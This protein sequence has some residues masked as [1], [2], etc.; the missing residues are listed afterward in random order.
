LAQT[1]GSILL[2]GGIQNGARRPGE[3]EIAL[4]DGCRQILGGIF[5]AHPYACTDLQ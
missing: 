2:E 3:H 1:G 4:L 5:A